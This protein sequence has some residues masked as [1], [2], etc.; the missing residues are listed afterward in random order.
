MAIGYLGPG[1]ALRPTAG[2]GVPERGAEKR[3]DVRK[4]ADIGFDAPIKLIRI[5]ID[6]YEGLAGA[7]RPIV[8]TGLPHIESSAQCQ[9]AVRIPQD[10]IRPP[11]AVGP[12]HSDATSP[13]Y[14]LH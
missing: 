10:E 11:V 12:S 5:D 3:T 8:S 6:P 4:H 13:R 9:D 14:R 1:L 2:A 7:K